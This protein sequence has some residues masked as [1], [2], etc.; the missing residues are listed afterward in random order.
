MGFWKPSFCVT[1]AVYK[2]LKLT[3]M[4]LIFVGCILLRNVYG[5]NLSDIYL[6]SQLRVFFI[7]PEDFIIAFNTC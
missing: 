4:N 3:N 2:L 1:K 5:K 6:Q 7:N